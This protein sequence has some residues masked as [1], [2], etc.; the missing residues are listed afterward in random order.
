MASRAWS[1]ASSRAIVAGIRP[2]TAIRL[3]RRAQLVVDQLDFGAG[4]QHEHVAVE[5]GQVQQRPVDLVADR[6]GAP[7][8]LP[9]LEVLGGRRRGAL[10][11]CGHRPGRTLAVRATELA[12]LGGIQGVGDRSCVRGGGVQ[13]VLG[14][15]EARR[16]VTQGAGDGQDL[17]APEPDLLV[18]G[19][20]PC[21]AQV[22][23]G[24]PRGEGGQRRIDAL[25]ADQGVGDIGRGGRAE[26]DVPGAGGDRRQHVLGRGRAQ[27]PHRPRAG[28]L[29]RLEQGVARDV[30]QPVGVLDDQ[31][32]P[33]PHDRGHR[34]APDEVQ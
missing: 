8:L 27:D 13:Q 10:D 5:A 22:A 14:G 11:P 33:A 31:D 9:R 4:L 30:V 26:P 20:R 19:E 24:G 7:G 29:Q 21:P 3:E 32:V 34:G 15:E 1:S 18:A 2:C 23:L 6:A 12:E 28:L 25:A 17:A 16:E